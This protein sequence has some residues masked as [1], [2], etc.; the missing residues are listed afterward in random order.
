M[1]PEW[2]HWYYLI[3][4]LP[5]AIAVFVLLLSGLGGHH[6][7]HG[8]A[9]HGGFHAHGHA[10]GLH[11]HAHGV[12]Q[13]AHGAGHGPAHG[14]HGHGSQ[15]RSGTHHAARPSS[16]GQNA[17]RQLLGFLGIG[18]APIAFV[19][20]CLMIGWGLFGAL[21][22]TLLQPVLGYPLLF[23]PPALL[24]A[25]A[26][27]ILFARLFGGL[28]ARYMPQ[29]E[30]YAIPRDGL[31]GLTG[32]VVFPVTE[33]GGRVHIFDAHRT[34]HAESARIAPGVLPIEKGTEVIVTCMDPQR[35]WLVVEPLGFHRTSELPSQTEGPS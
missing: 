34:L 27:G 19:L 26:G 13:A 21:A 8:H 31:V 1:S 28:A 23:V 18:R 2:L 22:I 30:S 16:S 6:G 32:K 4:L 7:G 25:A 9:H 3:F 5:A 35:R 15:V 14:S 10:A 20:G 12:G 11:G 17:L 24:M 29:D 33:S